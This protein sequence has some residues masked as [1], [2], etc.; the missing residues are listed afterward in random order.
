M[1]N[2]EECFFIAPIGDEGSD[3]RERS[4]TL[5]EYIVEEAVSD[6]DILPAVNGED[7][8]P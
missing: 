4:D 3:I 7:S 8:R 5:M 2:N 1:S 6:F